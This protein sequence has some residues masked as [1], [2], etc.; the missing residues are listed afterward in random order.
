VDGSTA[1]VG[2]AVDYG[3]GCAK[4]IP[5]TM[6][7][8]ILLVQ[9]GECLFKTKALHA[10]VTGAIALIVVSVRLSS[11]HTPNCNNHQPINTRR[12]PT[13]SPL[14]LLISLPQKT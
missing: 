14:S 4:P 7:G 1:L 6:V 12:P 9:R 13:Y 10:Q 5:R 8:K 11:S 2:T 3:L